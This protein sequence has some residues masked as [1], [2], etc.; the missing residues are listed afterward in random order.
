MLIR[1]IHADECDAL[2]HVTVDAYRHLDNS[3]PLGPYEDELRNVEARR[4]D[5]EVYVVLDEDGALMG[6]VTYVPGPDHA[7]AEFSEPGGCGIRMLAIDPRFQGRGAGRALVETCISRAREQR[8]ER[9]IL[10]STPTMTLAQ[11]MYVRLGFERIPEL[12]EFVNESPYSGDEP[13]HLRAF[14]LTV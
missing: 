5:S 9:I 3:E 4:L 2:A 7:M 6:G 1:L 11:A 13:L 14:V 10:H 8:R 12:D